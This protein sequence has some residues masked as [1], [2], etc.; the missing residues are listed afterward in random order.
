MFPTL[1]KARP[2]WLAL[3]AFVVTGAN[4]QDV[5][6]NEIHYDNSGADTGEFIEVAGPAGTNLSNFSLVLYNGN[7]GAPY[8]TVALAGTL[9]D[10]GGSG[11]GALSFA[12]A[13]IQNGSPDGIAL[14]DGASLV[15]F[16]SY[17]G[18]FTASGGVADGVA[19]TDI[20]VSEPNN[21]PVGESLQL[22]GTGSVYTDF[23]WEGPATSTV[24][25]SNNNQ[26]FAGGSSAV[27][28]ISEIHYDNAG[29]DTGEAIEVSGTAGADLSG[30][31]LVLY[32]GNGG[33]AYNTIALSGLLPNEAG[34]LGALSFAAP[35]LQNGSPDGIA[36][37][38]PDSNVVEFLSYEGSL[39]AVDGPADGLVST[40]IGVSEPNNTP[41]G[42]SL[43]LSGCVT[44]LADLAW[45]GPSVESFGALNFEIVSDIADCDS[46]GE[47]PS[48]G[49]VFI[50]ELHYDNDGGDV[51]EGVEVA[52]TAGTDLSGW[53]LVFYNGSNG[54]V[55]RTES[56]SG[57]IP[58]QAEGFGTAAISLPSNGI[59]NGSPDGLALVNP[60]SEVVQFISYE[61]TLTAVGGPADGQTSTDIGVS[62]TND[63]PI[64]FSLQVT[65]CSGGEFTW[66]GP[67]AESFGAV[68]DGQSFDG[69]A[70]CLDG[71]GGG[72]EE[73]PRVVTVPEI[74][75]D[76]EAT[77]ISGETIRVSG[78]VTGAFPA[79]P[80][81]FLQ[82]AGDG[83]PATSD[84][85]FVFT[86]NSGGDVSVGD[87]VTVDGTAAERFDQ[88]QV[89]ATSVTV[90]GT[91][92]LPAPVVIG[93]PVTE[94]SDLEAFEGMLVQVTQTMTVTEI[95]NLDR[96]GELLLS[97]EGRQF[98][99]SQLNT[100]DATAF[101]GFV[102]D[103]ARN[104]LI[105]DDDANGFIDGA[106][107]YP[108][109][110]LSDDNV[111]RIGDTITGV[112]GNLDFGFGQYRLRPT[113]EFTIDNVNE[114]PASPPD[115]GGRLKVVSFNV[116][117]FFNT[118][119]ERGADT[120][121]ELSIQIDKLVAALSGLDADVY[122]LIE[123]EN[124][125][126]EGAAS[127]IAE[128]TAALN[129]ANA[130]SCG[131]NYDYLA[132]T[133]ADPTEDLIAVGLIYCA[134][135][136]TQA[137]GTELAVLNDT[138]LTELGLF[139]RPLFNE[140]RTNRTPIA[141]TFEELATG[142]R[143]TVTVNHFKSKG[144]SGSVGT[145][146]EDQGDG[147]G[148]WN[149]IRTEASQALLAWLDTA[150]TGSDDPDIAILGDLNAYA[151]ET[152]ITTLEAAGFEDLG[153]RTPFTYGYVFGG[154]SGTL[155]YIL[156]SPDLSPD[157]T[158]FG[159]WHINADE[160]GAFEY[161]NDLANPA[162]PFRTS[163]HD[164]ALMG[165]DLDDTIAPELSC[166]TPEDGTIR[167]W[168]RGISFTAEASD[169][170][171][172][173]PTVE[174]SNVRCVREFRRFTWPFAFCRVSTDGDT[175]TLRRPGGL[176]NRI[177]WTATA[178]D[179][180]GNETSAHCSVK[181]TFPRRRR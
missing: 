133:E 139:T 112:T 122:G 146:D 39:T 152:P 88:T 170:Q 71:D 67:L 79:L 178:T 32:N 96:F 46:G 45:A 28:F 75:G 137:A 175:I 121:E 176:K 83:N 135:T 51:G 138:V 120:D 168:N 148:A 111:V 158:G 53:L 167:P 180:A 13:G 107:P 52:G 23:T 1:F 37:V 106:P 78:V 157:V 127:S 172:A 136:V 74:Q 144:S 60:A 150:P 25:S 68:N 155:D 48:D 90:T 55:Y 31:S 126:S 16:L 142:E 10:E 98:Q 19:S 154:A 89:A 140:R 110:A 115:V 70:E 36:L 123:L 130:T 141:A 57:V 11:F 40:D 34:S 5:F 43:Q 62:E 20:G 4:A 12:I 30:Y 113:A 160:S 149:A 164:P 103:Q 2:A 116:E 102:A 93:F 156:T 101:P 99:F 47:E 3:T 26:I 8:N 6:I 125:S 9:P 59:Q 41:I 109:P 161:A 21:T 94:V 104:R 105:L 128:L 162:S 85:V 66:V 80:G 147:A 145:I 174:L 33:A 169:A 65:A 22:G 15:Q 129:A 87:V 82:D 35:G 92:G 179:A 61:G 44:D 72:G 29:A 42:E 77:P 143:F 69:V 49:I 73:G 173:S 100:P 151:A 163:D 171:D 56:L 54:S 76:G 24:D 81:F 18:S 84:G 108:A 159:E 119:G 134:S 17:E 58:D 27:V 117:N 131:M 124:D 95:F 50:N 165:I 181:V 7:G 38:D 14:A 86:G 132:K 114:R 63:T 118:L 166:G 153:D 97:A 177:S 91:S 64:D